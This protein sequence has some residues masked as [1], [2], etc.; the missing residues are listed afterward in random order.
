M[1]LMLYHPRMRAG[2]TRDDAR[3]VARSILPEILTAD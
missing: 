1:L 3:T 2:I